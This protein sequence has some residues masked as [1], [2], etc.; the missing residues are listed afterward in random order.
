MFRTCEKKTKN[1]KN[2]GEPMP[3]FFSVGPPEWVLIQFPNF[4]ISNGEFGLIN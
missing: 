3:K 1:E 2:Q 4:L